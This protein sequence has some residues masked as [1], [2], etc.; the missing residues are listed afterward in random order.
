[1][2][3]EIERK[4]LVS[5]DQWRWDADGNE[6]EGV[7]F[8]QGYLSSKPEATVRVRMEGDAAKLTIKGKNKGLARAEFE[9]SIPPNEAEQLLSNLCEK[10]LIEKVRYCRKEGPFTWEIDVFEGDNQGLVVAEV[11]LESE[12]QTVHLPG[13][14]GEE[15]SHDARY[16]NANLVANPFK[17]WR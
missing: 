16:F 6:I 13:W 8:C 5:S 2:A 17:N 3:V 12:N 11:E 10:P 7:R 14:I 4:F 9:Y 1:M 15:V